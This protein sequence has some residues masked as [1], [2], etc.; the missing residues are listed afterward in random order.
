MAR[1]DEGPAV[2]IDLGTTYSCVGV[3]KNNDVEIIINQL[4]NRTT[5]SVVSFK[6]GRRLIGDPAKNQAAT[7]PTNTIFDAKRL[8]GRRFSDPIVQDDMKVWPFKV[9]ADADNKPKI[10]VTCGNE[11][12]QF[13]AEEI[14]SMV[15]RKMREI[16]EI[17][18]RKTVKNAVVT[19]PSYFNDSQRQ[20]TKD[21]GVIADLNILRIINEPT[22]A[23]IAYGLDKKDSSDGEINVFIFDL[24][25]GTFDVSLLRINRDKFEVLATN[26]DTHLGGEDI[27]YILLNHFVQEFKR[28]YNKDISGD[29]KALRRLKTACERAKRELSFVI[30]TT[31]AIDSLHMGID[32][33]TRITRSRFE[34]LNQEL[35]MKCMDT[36]EKCLSDAKMDRK[37]VHEVVMVGGS[38]RIPRVQQLL[39]ESF[40]GKD[41]CKS[42]NPDEAVAI[43]AATLAATLTG[44]G[45]G[46]IKKLSLLDVTPLSLG[47][48]TN[49]DTMS[50]VIPRN[51]SVPI[52][53]KETYSTIVDNQTHMQIR[54]YEGERTI[55]TAN[56]LLG[57]F[58]LP[59]LTPAPRHVT[60]VKVTFEID[61]NGILKVSAEEISR[62]KKKVKGEITIIND[63]GRLTKEEIDRIIREAEK[64]KDEDDAHKKKI[65]AMNALEN[66]AYKMRNTI[67]HRKINSK[68]SPEE[69]K[70]IEDAVESALNWFDAMNQL[71]EADEYKFSLDEL[72]SICQP[73]LNKLLN[74]EDD[75]A[76]SGGVSLSY[77][78]VKKLAGF[79]SRK[80]PSAVRVDNS[81]LVSSSSI[82]LDH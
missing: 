59:G 64:F 65:D 24:G 72:E 26:G 60:K 14:V 53:K 61:T 51:T 15:L 23:A 36:V 27:D 34:E 56:N 25:G 57:E 11:E 46:K 3:W 77:S 39:K 48:L 8:I 20:A 29:P 80:T 71:A 9:I 75:D 21:A 2:G 41:L 5:P 33:E 73:I 66:Y 52:K 45:K 43:G 70:K 69:K 47:I 32:F 81:H 58:T 49:E 74:D 35:F 19:V 55:A 44:Q 28:K 38:T 10:V 68:L 17:K 7:N 76:P 31:I 54:V 42:I 62:K 4:G 18:L 22:A 50:V 16:A 30:D 12:K 1:N 37:S 6:D 82:S 13:Y 78:T 79:L 40:D 63:K 67:N